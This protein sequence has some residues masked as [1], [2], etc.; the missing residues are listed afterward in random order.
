[1]VYYEYKCMYHYGCMYYVY[2]VCYVLRFRKVGLRLAVLLRSVRIGYVCFGL[3][4]FGEG[5]LGLATFCYF[6]IAY[7]WLGFAAFRYVWLELV[8]FS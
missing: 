7:V 6:S 4:G 3:A 8:P 2:Y 1:M 5:W